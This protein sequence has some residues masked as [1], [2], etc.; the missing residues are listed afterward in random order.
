ME[1]ISVRRAAALLRQAD[2]ILIVT[3]V[4]PDG[5]AAGSGCALCLGLRALGKTA[6]LVPNLPSMARY[7]K[8]M[9]AYF[10]P[11]GFVPGFVAAVDTPGPGQF[12][13]GWEHLAERTGLAVDHHGTNSGYARYTYLEADSAATG[14][15]VYLLLRELGVTLTA[16]MA[17]ALYAALA[18]DTNGF[19]TPG[20]TARTLTM[21]RPCPP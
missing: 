14:E 8:Y 3:H 21:P 17:E 12:P 11:E 5:D 1:R 15:L 6:W 20:T 10:A 19:R 18:T 13:P 9:T 7:E 16:D 4:R 2:D